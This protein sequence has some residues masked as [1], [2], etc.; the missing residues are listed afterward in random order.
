M[1][2]GPKK[3]MKLRRKKTLKE[4]SPADASSDR[5]TEGLSISGSMDVDDLDNDETDIPTPVRAADRP[6]VSAF[7]DKD[8]ASSQTEEWVRVSDFEVGTPTSQAGDN[9]PASEDASGGVRRSL[10]KLAEWESVSAD[11]PHA[12]REGSTNSLE[13][14]PS[15][16]EVDESGLEGASGHSSESYQHLPSPQPHVDKDS[17][18]MDGSSDRS[19]RSTSSISDAKS[20]YSLTNDPDST[21][22]GPDI[23]RAENRSYS[24]RD[25]IS[26]KRQE[27]LG[28][29]SEDSEEKGV[30]HEDQEFSSGVETS[31]ST[32]M[33]MKMDEEIKSGRSGIQPASAR[34]N[35]GK[36][37]QKA[38]EDHVK[39]EE[40]VSTTSEFEPPKSDTRAPVARVETISAASPEEEKEIVISDA[41]DISEV[42][43]PLDIPDEPPVSGEEAQ[44]AQEADEPVLPQEEEPAIPDEHVPGD[45]EKIWLAA[46]PSAEPTS[47]D[48]V[49]VSGSEDGNG[50]STLSDEKS[51]ETTTIFASE[52]PASA[53]E[54]KEIASS[55]A[56]TEEAKKISADVPTFQS[57]TTFYEKEAASGDHT[58][59]TMDS[60][61]MKP[62]APSSGETQQEAVIVE[63]HASLDTTQ[64]AAAKNAMVAGILRPHSEQESLS[65]CCGVIY[66][67][68]G[69]DH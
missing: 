30:V 12:K 55:S 54:E 22:F 51:E 6:E 8:A 49:Q 5:D 11:S 37:E 44:E 62:L 10:D 25:A 47:Q 66:W 3:R 64:P 9:E 45:D 18:E 31:A 39:E 59:L 32:E 65:G 36:D 63:R 33:E 21:A 13:E 1:P 69:R 7:D 4:G 28:D 41:K 60:V 23:K 58:E 56:E 61:S 43:T 35:E 34:E 17:D 24:Y 42:V 19:G 15:E 53:V 40:P 46:T 38:W 14:E 16:V 20:E 67:L 68:L 27:D 26:S 2:S 57:A 48:L 50:A 52:S 29:K